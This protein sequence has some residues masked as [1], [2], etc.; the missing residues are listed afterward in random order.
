MRRK[1]YKGVGCVKQSLSK[2]E[3]VCKAY[4]KIQTAFAEQLQNDRG[5]IS[6]RCN[7]PI[8][9]GDEENQYT[10]DFV[11]TKRD[12]ARMVRECV[13]RKHLSKPLTIRLL[14]LSRNFWLAH[15]VEDWDIVIE[16]EA[17]DGNE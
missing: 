1:G 14:D 16:R 13:W 2:C 8:D 7:V 6:F 11:A 3:G 9:S 4:D 15:G 10:T 17:Q 5:I 12:N